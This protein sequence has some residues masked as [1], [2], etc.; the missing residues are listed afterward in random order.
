[1]FCCRNIV[2]ESVAGP[3]FSFNFTKRIKVKGEK[4]DDRYFILDHS[5]EVNGVFKIIGDY[6]VVN[7][8]SLKFNEDELQER[9]REDFKSNRFK[10][11]L[12]QRHKE[13]LKNKY[14][15]LIESIK[16]S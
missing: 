3:Q 8:A 5:I 13:S 4:D 6:I 7:T 16:E 14:T 9:I 11:F 10:E 15:E 2:P 12:K 1:M